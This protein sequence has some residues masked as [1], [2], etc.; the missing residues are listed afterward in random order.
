[1]KKI[2]LTTF[3]LSLG[4]Y[5]FADNMKENGEKH[6]YLKA[7]GNLYSE[8]ST[9]KNKGLT[10]GKS[11]KISNGKTDDFGYELAI[12]I[13]KNVTDSLELGLG[14][15]YQKNSELKKYN[16][17]QLSNETL[18][19]TV[20]NYNSIPV[21]LTGKY[22]FDAINNWKPYLKANLGYSFNIQEKDSNIPNPFPAEYKTTVKNGLYTGLGV[23]VEYN[24][25]LVDLTYSVNYAKAALEL[26]DNPNGDRDY[27]KT[28]SQSL[29]YS[30]LTLSVGYKFD[31]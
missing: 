15:A 22:N 25:F 31:Y 17:M 16:V 26:K 18:S 9:Y 27:I 20:G 12:E 14:V 4:S 3:I 13:T 8:Y 2:L 24:N 19:N 29:N 11:Q 30:K 7:G 28:K 23:G 6:L 21:Y 5:A 1:M 10:R